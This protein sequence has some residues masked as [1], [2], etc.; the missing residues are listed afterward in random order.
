MAS[1]P[2]TPRIKVCGLR[3]LSAARAAL[4]AGAD[5]LGLVHHAA[6]PRHVAPD[7]ARALIAALDTDALCVGVLLDLDPRDALQLA[8]AMGVGALQLC[9]SED[10]RDW[11]DF[12]LPL[13][14]RLAVDASGER[15][16][17]RWRGVAAG[18][19]L[20]HPAV[21]GG[22]GRAVDLAQA[23]RLARLA[24]CLL[25][26]GLDR[27]SV[28]AAVAAVRPA[29]VDASSRLESAP[30][31]KDVARVRAFVRAAGA[32]LAEVTA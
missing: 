8:R 2:P 32:A 12:E 24:P 19:V 6:S 18:F 22:G 25:A 26:G 21:P 9:G 23:A 15:E 16:L 7:A 27:D 29:G 14:R 1:P 11:G 10:P 28:A 30:G 31:V 4:E 3:D 17:E 20:D 13:L 5:A